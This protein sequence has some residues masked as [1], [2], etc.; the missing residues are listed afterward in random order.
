MAENRKS[1][2]RVYLI[3]AGPGDPGLLTVKA[4]EL[5]SVCD[6]VLYDNLVNPDILKQA[7]QAE[8]VYAGKHGDRHNM[9]Q[10]QINRLMISYARQGRTV[11]RLKGGD[12]FVFGRGG[13]E[14]LVLAEARIP[15]EVVP[16][17]SAGWAVP[18]Y[19]GIPLTHRR[20]ASTV[21]FVT[22]HEDPTKHA[23]AINWGSLATGVDTLVFFMC[24]RNL[25]TIVTNLICHG[26]PPSTP[27]AVIC[28]G[29]YPKQQSYTGT[30]ANILERIKPPIP[31]PAMAVVGEVVGLHEELNWFESNHSTLIHEWMS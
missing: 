11:V 20:Y 2:G 30:L 25:P 31:S 26:R 17:V 19:A 24:G 18:A 9:T 1:I 14:A 27:V 15:F 12:P 13:E 3:G 6:C 16:G 21:A 10:E 29:T 4:R 28:S 5:L 22:G 23:S 8:L 7:S